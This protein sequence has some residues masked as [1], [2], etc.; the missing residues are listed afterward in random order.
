M[1][2][3]DQYLQDLGIN[4]LPEDVKKEIIT[5]LE[6][7]IQDAITIRIMEKL[8]TE[9]VDE[10]NGLND[11]SVDDV[12]AWLTKVSP[13][14]ATSPEFLDS[15]AKSGAKEGDF[16]RQY[17]ILKWLG[18]NV[19]DYNQIVLEV[20]ASTKGEILALQEHIAKNKS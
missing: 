3:D 16:T 10:F 1:L 2:L 13:Y 18:M 14:Y 15:K 11:G 5:G 19:P 7:T 20:L 17:A 9:L 4:E 6:Q 8:S 12:K